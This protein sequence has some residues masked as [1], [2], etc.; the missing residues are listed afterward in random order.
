MTSPER[1]FHDFAAFAATLKGD[2]KSEAQIFL[3]HL[4][5]AFEQTSML[6]GALWLT[7]QPD[8]AEQQR[9]K[10]ITV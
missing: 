1:A 10:T 8:F 4:L 3:F 9:N 5:E 7:S 2:V 6:A